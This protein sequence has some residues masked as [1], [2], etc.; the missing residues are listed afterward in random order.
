MLDFDLY[1][2]LSHL[3]DNTKEL[4]TTDLNV[5]GIIKN[6]NKQITSLSKDKSWCQKSTC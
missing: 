5:V 3:V 1:H 6:L 2:M 4:V